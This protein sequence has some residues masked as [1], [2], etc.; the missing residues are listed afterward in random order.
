MSA[1]QAIAAIEARDGEIRAVWHLD[2]TA[3]GAWPVLVKDN[4]A[5]AGMPWTA[6]LA[7]YAGRI[8]ETDA[9]CIAALRHAGATILGKL[10][11]HE[12]ALGATTDF[13]RPCFN[14]LRA[15]YTPGGSS[16]GSGAAVAA[17]YVRAAIGSDTM[18][19]VRI[20]AAYCGV[21]GLKPTAGLIGRSGVTPLSATLDTVGVVAATPRE[22]LAAL[23]A[24]VTPDEA[25]PAW[26]PAPPGWDAVPDIAPRLALARPAWDAPM[27]AAIADAARAALAGLSLDEA[28]MLLWRPGAARR[29][30]LLLVEA[31]GAVVHAALLDDPTAASAGF[32]S[33]LAYGRDAGTPRL[34]RALEEIARARAAAW[35]ALASADALVLPTT[36]QRAFPQGAPTPADQA[37]FTAL[38]N[39]AGLP[40]IAFPVPAPDGGLPGSLQ[41]V[42]PPWSEGRLVAIAE[43]LMA[44]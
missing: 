25:D 43:R 22:A 11:L 32:R 41:L 14:P 36:P 39:L 5:V 17:G 13:P 27:E 8:A 15:G 29:A 1:E 19:S 34:V 44:R 10:A 3:R 26:L 40:A 23:A 42:G 31:E 30:G 16:G 6:G 37:D 20:P 28:P 21:V 12:G 7:A 33:A 4:I 35:R 9:P 24:M 18:G 2:R 38:A